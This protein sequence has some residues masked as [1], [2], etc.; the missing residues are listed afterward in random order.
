M[1]FGIG[2]VTGH[3]NRFSVLEIDGVELHLAR[4]VEEIPPWIGQREVLL[5]L[6]TLDGAERDYYLA[7]LGVTAG[8][9]ECIGLERQCALHHRVVAR[10]VG[11]AKHLPDE[12]GPVR[13]ITIDLTG[14]EQLHPLVVGLDRRQLDTKIVHLRHAP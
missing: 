7:E 12:H 13:C 8:D 9:H 10:D 5:Q 14:V 11:I 4:P 3:A 6:A 2:L 1:G